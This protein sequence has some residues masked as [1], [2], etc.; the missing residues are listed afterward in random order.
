MACLPALILGGPAAG[1]Q[2]HAPGTRP[3]VLVFADS[4]YPPYVVGEMGAAPSGGVTLDVLREIGRRMGI[5][6]Q[7]RL[8]PWKRVLENVR[9]GR[10]DGVTTL[11]VT[12]DRKQFLVYTDMFTQSRELFFYNREQTPDFDW[13]DYADLNGLSIGLVSGYTYGQE[14]LEAARRLNM[15]IEYSP[16]DQTAYAKLARGRIDLVLDDERSGKLQIKNH[17][18]LSGVIL[19]HQKPV[20]VY[21]YHM[22]FSRKSRARTLVDEVN[23]V[24]DRM[25]RDNTLERLL[26]ID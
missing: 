13:T 15:D 10:V 26:T 19:A 23:R 2:S 17:P 8:M 12:E 20:T 4:P 3:D 7:V 14:F 6:I 18:A 5:D 11:M 9:T 24:L 25:R 22:A 21:D 16:T 1:A